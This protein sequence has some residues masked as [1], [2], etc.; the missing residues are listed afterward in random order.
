LP[1]VGFVNRTHLRAANSQDSAQC[2]PPG[3]RM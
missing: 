2:H 3:R 1:A